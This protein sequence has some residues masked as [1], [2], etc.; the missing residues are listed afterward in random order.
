M[1]TKTEGRLVLGIFFVTLQAYFCFLAK[2][3]Y[4]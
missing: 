3:L 1:L 2:K 4:L